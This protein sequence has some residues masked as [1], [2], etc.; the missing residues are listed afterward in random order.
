MNNK[1]LLLTLLAVLMLATGCTTDY[2]YA[3]SFIRKHRHAGKE[4]TEQLYVCLPDAV[5]HTNSSLNDVPDFY[6]LSYEEQ[7]SLIAAKTDILNRIDDSIFLSQF[8]GMFLYT[9]SRLRVPVIVVS[10]PS[11]LP[12][13]DDDHLV[14]NFVQFE[15]EE[16]VQPSRS[17]FYTTRGYYYAYDYDLRHFAL[18][19]WLQFCEPAD[20]NATVFFKNAEISEG[21]QGTV[22][23]LKDDHAT[24]K[25]NFTRIDANDAYQLARQLGRDCATLYVERMLTEYV[26]RKKG[27]NNSYFYYNPQTDRIDVILPYEHGIKESFEKVN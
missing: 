6:L 25:T 18:N 15:A 23:A 16:Y 1:R 8:N 2:H 7:D 27:T 12:K 13:A 10:D 19:V 5:I 20:T 17:S 14:I 24:L 9:L 4:A 22:T 3:N 26:C 11:R 21:F